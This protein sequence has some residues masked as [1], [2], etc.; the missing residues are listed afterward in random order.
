SLVIG[1]A[2]VNARRKQL[3]AVAPLIDV[4]RSGRAN[5]AAHGHYCAFPALVKDGL[6]GFGADFAEAIHTSHVMDSV[7]QAT[8]SGFFTKPIP[9]IQS[10]L[11]RIASFPSLHPPLP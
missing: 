9:I 8:S 1:A 4:P 3:D 2:E 6:V 5:G 11:P 10:L 7:H